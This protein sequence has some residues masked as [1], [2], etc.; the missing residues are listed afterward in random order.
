LG[1]A[2]AG[3]GTYA[4]AQIAKDYLMH[5]KHMMMFAAAICV[6]SMLAYLFVFADAPIA[7]QQSLDSP[8]AAQ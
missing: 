2:P 6:F 8:A 3:Q 5:T 1:L 4:S 7:E